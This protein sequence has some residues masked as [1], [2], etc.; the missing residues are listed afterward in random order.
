MCLKDES[1]ER[2]KVRAVLPGSAAA[3]DGLEVDDIL[4]AANGQPL[5]G[6]VRE[7]LQP[8]LRT[9]EP[10]TFDIERAGARA[11]VKVKPNPRPGAQD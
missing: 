6:A 1:R 5:R 4:L 8:F 11:Q 10:I 3:R 9:G 2:V 7:I